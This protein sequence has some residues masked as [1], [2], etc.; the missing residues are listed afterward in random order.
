MTL[1]FGRNDTILVLSPHLDDAILSLGGSIA[2]WTHAGASVTI[3]TV[4]TADADKHRSKSAIVND[5]LYEEIPYATGQY[6]VIN[7]DNVEAAK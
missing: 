4:F 7:P 5:M 2:A 1:A 3:L 6:P